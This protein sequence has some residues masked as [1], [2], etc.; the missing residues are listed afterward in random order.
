[1]KKPF[2][3][4]CAAV[5]LTVFL[6]LPVFQS[7]AQN[8]KSY[9]VNAFGIGTNSMNFRETVESGTHE[10]DIWYKWGLVFARK[11]YRV[12]LDQ[13]SS[14]GLYTG[15]K[16]E[17]ILPNNFDFKPDD[18]TLVLPQLGGDLFQLGLAMSLK[19]TDGMNI[20]ANAGAGATVHFTMM[21][22]DLIDMTWA[23]LS[24]GITPNVGVRAL[25]SDNFSIGLSHRIGSTTGQRYIDGDKAGDSF[26]FSVS[27]FYLTIAF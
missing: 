8:G 17:I 7:L 2:N 11:H 12:N 20:V 25:L 1:M 26:S 22:N 10:S 13:A 15:S 9:R 16:F 24:Y 4:R 3:Y 19:I 5:L 14:F 27:A 18:H 21:H 6:L 23:Q